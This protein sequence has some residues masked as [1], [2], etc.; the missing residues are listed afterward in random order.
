MCCVYADPQGRL[1]ESWFHYPASL[2][3]A[4]PEWLRPHAEIMLQYQHLTACGVVV[5][6]DNRGEIGPHGELVLSLS[7]A[8][9]RRMVEGVVSVADIFF[10][11]GALK[12]FPASR[13][14]FYIRR[15][16]RD[17]DIRKFREGIRGPADLT[18]STAHPQGG[19]A[20]GRHK[21]RSVVS[22]AFSLYDFPNLFVADA[23]LF[24]AG[25]DVNPQMTA[26]ALAWLAAD[27]VLAAG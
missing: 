27:R 9:L 15:E 24:P 3:I 21:L 8:E 17:E 23:S 26:M 7:E 1:L 16:K 10:E 11:A 25:C 19:N 22:P 20:L 6:T 14:P 18:L 2:A 12:V 5:P 4:L 13:M